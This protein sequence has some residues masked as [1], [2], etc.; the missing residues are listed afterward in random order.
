M[1]GGQ[2]SEM[3]FQG[4]HAELQQVDVVADGGQIL[5]LPDAA[6]T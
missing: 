3:L 6:E 1:G 2:G 4:R 5:Q